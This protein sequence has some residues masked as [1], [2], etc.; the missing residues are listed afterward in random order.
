[1]GVESFSYRSYE[2]PV[3]Y[4]CSKCQTHG[5]KLWRVYQTMG[6]ELCCAK[7]ACEACDED[8]DP[9][10][11][12]DDGMRP[13]IKEY[14]QPGERTDQIGIWIPAV[15]DEEGDGFWGYTSVPDWGC[16]W[17]KSLPV[18]AERR[19]F[20]TLFPSAEIKSQNSEDILF[21]SIQ[22][23]LLKENPP[24]SIMLD[25]GGDEKSI[26]NGMKILYR[27]MEKV[28]MKR[29][30]E[31]MD[32]PSV[33]FDYSISMIEKDNCTLVRFLIRPRQPGC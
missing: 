29:K 28:K 31:W 22:D 11:I 30:C 19:A 3:G 15:P 32:E 1:M 16:E 6:I 13:R 17:W 4:T 10:T 26:V 27:V 33:V 18:L 20:L 7:C 2:V 5:V 25:I 12:D 14:A 23:L 9:K 24:T 8:I 21:K